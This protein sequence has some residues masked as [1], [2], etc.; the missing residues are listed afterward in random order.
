[1]IVSNCIYSIISYYS[2]T[3]LLYLGKSLFLI[4]SIFPPFIVILVTWNANSP[5]YLLNST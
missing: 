1:M 5:I 2:S 3:D 4:F